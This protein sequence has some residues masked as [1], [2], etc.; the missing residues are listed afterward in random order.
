MKTF[1]HLF[2]G[3]VAPHNWVID[4]EAHVVMRAKRMFLQL[5]RQ[6]GQALQLTDTLDNC[7]D[8]LW[9]VERYPLEMEPQDAAHL[10]ARAAAHVEKEAVVHRILAGMVKLDSVETAHPLRAYQLQAV[11]LL[12]TNGGLLLADE[13]GLG[14]TVSAIGA[15]VDARLRP[16]AVITLTALPKQWEAELRH[17]AP[18]LTTHIVKTGQ[19]YDLT[20]LGRKPKPG[21]LS[22]P[23]LVPD[24]IICPYSKLVG[25]AETLSAICKSVV[26]DEVQE[27]RHGT[28]S[29][30]GSAGLALAAAMRYRLGLSG[31]PIYN[32][33]AE[34]FPVMQ[35]VA[36][37]V[38]GS[39]DEFL[40]E[41]CGAV[42]SRG[43]SALKNPK[44]F[45]TYVRETG[46]MLRRNKQDVGIETPDCVRVIH[47]I[48]ADQEP[49]K[50]IETAAVNLARSILL[51][52][53]LSSFDRMR[54]AGE[55]DLMVRQATGVAKA[56]YVAEFVKMLLE[57]GEQVL[58]FGWH[59]DVY[60]IWAE[61][62]KK[63]EPAFYT[64]TESVPQKNA[65]KEAFISGKSRLLIMSLRSGAGI[66]GLQQVCRTVV[67]GELDWSP[68][69]MEQNI[70][71][72]DRP[73][74]ER[75]VNVFFPLSDEGS[76]PPMADVLQVKRAQVE[77]IREPTKDVEIPH[78]SDGS[79]IKELARAYLERA[80]A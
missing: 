10:A 33:G 51:K 76:D 18:K 68:A 9:F 19:P 53:E 49:L 5:H 43:R 57:N 70:A 8:L 62:L 52:S 28:S 32:L 12:L 34:M 26:F 47:H 13:M 75:L 4:A 48:E 42:D 38:L 20:A 36:P 22:I 37:G 21:Q 56:P 60:D 31:T 73:G 24:V 39:R 25:W 71:R 59:R 79:R 80:T 1:G 45:G 29:Q 58:L 14:K 35:A 50:D 7:R 3:H 23:G 11:Q 72:I 66:D 69:V 44:A 78:E 61:R 54:A 6:H 67:F 17:F 41:W 27:L 55:M 74:Q 63:Y 65:A 2:R 16:A 64:G 77:G 15:L 40:K 30:K 46:L